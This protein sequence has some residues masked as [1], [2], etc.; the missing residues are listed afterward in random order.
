MARSDGAKAVAG[1]QR[2]NAI[3]L[4]LSEGGE[5]I[6]H[7]VGLITNIAGQTNLPALNATIEAAWRRPRREVP[8]PRCVTRRAM[9]RVRPSN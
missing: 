1:A 3:V 2:T 4:A 9:C 6:G 8:L 7:V 5:K